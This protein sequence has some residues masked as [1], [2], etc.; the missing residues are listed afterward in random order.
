[1]KR[2]LLVAVGFVVLIVLVHHQEVCFAQQNGCCTPPQ[3]ETTAIEVNALGQVNHHIWYDATALLVRWDR[4]G[5]IESPNTITY[6]QMWINYTINPQYGVPMEYI[7][8]PTHPN[9]CVGDGAD[10][11]N[12]WCYGPLAGGQSFVSKV[13]IAGKA[14][15]LWGNM[16]N[17]FQWISDD[18]SCL[19]ISIKHEA[20][21]MF[22]IFTNTTL[23]IR[24]RSVFTPPAICTNS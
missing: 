3:W 15:T 22:T 21:S 9:T 17:G 2:E 13:T 23:G 12:K 18:S 16:G 8:D 20:D 1:M 6:E 19:P 5:N 7:Y 11:F 24:D 14:C 4:T 10:A